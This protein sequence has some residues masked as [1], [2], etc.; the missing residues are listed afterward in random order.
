MTRSRFQEVDRDDLMKR[1]QKLY[2]WVERNGMAGYDPHDVL[3]D[4]R[5]MKIIFSTNPMV[6]LLPAKVLNAFVR[7][8]PTATRRVFGIRPQVNAKGVGLFASAYLQFFLA[9]GEKKYRG[10]ALEAL[11]WLTENR[12]PG[13]H[14]FC[15]GYP[16]DWQS[17]I[18]I[19]RGTPSSV[20]SYTIGEAFWTAYLVL[21]D[22]RFLTTCV[23]IC[24]FF[25]NDLNRWVDDE[26]ICFSYT[27]LDRFQVHN[28]NL[29][30]A[31]FLV[32]IGKAIGNTDYTITGIK[33][34]RFA[35]SQQHPDGTL[36][37]MGQDQND[38]APNRNDHYHVGFEIRSLFRLWKLTG[39][40]IYLDATQRYFN[41]Y[42]N[43]MIEEKGSYAVPKLY[44]HST[45]PI[46]VHACS[47]AIILNTMLSDTFPE[48]ARILPGLYAWIVENMQADG[49]T[50]Y[51]RIHSLA[52]TIRYV[53]RTPHIRWG[54][55]WM[56]YA[57]SLLLVENTGI[58]KHME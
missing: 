50:F 7:Y 57:L 14:G 55:A 27:P 31:E 17:R 19:P 43:N 37:Y 9:T 45:Y 26:R 21:G 30:V 8:L 58:L 16:F 56:L 2:D 38:Q 49:G 11:A 41:Y 32:R 6:Q 12:S 28:A 54:Q 29:F 13:Y 39:D 23:S 22:E 5:V 44:R 51:H 24:E 1:S 33:A 10:R 34:T 46:D 18:F 25:L 52:G 53:D 3:G 48:A 20:V 36:D 40:E 4:P 47:E 35:L 42:V 15:W